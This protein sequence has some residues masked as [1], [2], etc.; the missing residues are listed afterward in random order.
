MTWI[1]ICGITN[2]EDAQTAVDAGADALGFVFHEKSPRKIDPEKARDITAALPDGI[3]KVGVFAFG[4]FEKAQEIAKRSGLTRLQLHT[5]SGLSVLPESDKAV[6]MVGRTNFYFAVPAAWVLAENSVS[7]NLVFILEK[8]LG[9][10]FERILID[11]GAPEQPGGTGKT[12][13]WNRAAP[14]FEKLAANSNMVVAGGLNPGNVG[15]A[16]RIL[17][18]WGVDVSSGVEFAP[19]KKDPHKVRAFVDAVRRTGKN[20]Q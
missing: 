17:K 12:F 4:N 20:N 6:G 14:F 16:I 1:K 3:E 19:G 2:V 11:S 7:A 13:D 10:P 18:P 15:E 5:A 8:K 9:P